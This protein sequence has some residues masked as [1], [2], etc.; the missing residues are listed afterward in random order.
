MSS[1]GRRVL[2]TILHTF[3]IAV[4][5]A[6]QICAIGVVIVVRPFDRVVDPEPLGIAEA[7]KGAERTVWMNSMGPRRDNIGWDIDVLYVVSISKVPG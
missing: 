5:E 2:P 1:D 7:A 6:M 4:E 3:Q